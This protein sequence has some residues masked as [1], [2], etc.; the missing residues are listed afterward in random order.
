[1]LPIGLL[2]A[3]VKLLKKIDSM[4]NYKST[5]T[6]LYYYFKSSSVRC[7]RLKNF[8]KILE[9]PELKIT[10]MHDIRW[11]SFYK[12]LDGIYRSWTALVTYFDSTELSK[13]PKATGLRKSILQFVIVIVALTWMLMDVIPVV[14]ALNLVFQKEN[15]DIGAVK[16]AVSTTISILKYL[17]DNDGFHCQELHTLVKGNSLY[18]HKLQG[19]INFSSVKYTM[20]KFIDNLIGN[21]K[22]RFPSES[23]S[24][25]SAFNCLVMR[26]LSFVDKSR[27][28]EYGCEHLEILLDHYGKAKGD[29]ECEAI[30]NPILVRQ[31][32]KLLKTLLLDM[33]YPRDQL[34]VLWKIIYECH[35][36]LFQNIIVLAMIALTLTV[37]T[38]ICE[39]GF[40]TQNNIKNAH[41]NRLG[42]MQLRTL[43]TISIEGP[44][45]KDF[46][47]RKALI[48][49]KTKKNGRIFQKLEMDE[50]VKSNVDS[51]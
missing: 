21:I 35:G 26:D 24:V 2:Y 41:R 8:Q 40:S 46:D 14:T 25:V 1:M 42:E 11:F 43:M 50:L 37:Q 23:L 38:A 22:N 45:V 18:D 51:S 39:R 15:L 32:Y 47:A 48:E 6:N 31:E 3:Q 12:V 36:D 16:P 30:V 17:K 33:K 13:D 20:D 44:P 9:M 49:F 27:L 7:S 5:L 34:K 28:D 10:E 4:T 19:Q 29:P